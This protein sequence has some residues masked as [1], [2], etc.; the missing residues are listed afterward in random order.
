MIVVIVYQYLL[1]TGT[2]FIYF[3]VFE[4]HM[5]T[6]GQLNKRKIKIYL[7]LKKK[8]NYNFCFFRLLASVTL[9][10]RSFQG[11]VFI[12][13]LPNLVWVFIGLIVSMGLLLVKIAV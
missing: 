3:D 2:G 12:L 9:S 4:P 11:K 6:T 1:F 5:V 10:F 8:K 13:S 7:C